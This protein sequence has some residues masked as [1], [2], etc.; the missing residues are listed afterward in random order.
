MR[1][2]A[3]E[4]APTA[5]AEPSESRRSAGCPSANAHCRIATA[6]AA[7]ATI[8]ARVWVKSCQVKNGPGTGT[9][10]PAVQLTCESTRKNAQATQIETDGAHRRS[11]GARERTPRPAHATNDPPA[12]ISSRNTSNARAVG[13]PVA[14]SSL[15]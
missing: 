9:G 1:P 2:P 8:A 10:H 12:T 14:P 7:N 11:T 3:A 15:T 4:I 13:M 5:I 6:A